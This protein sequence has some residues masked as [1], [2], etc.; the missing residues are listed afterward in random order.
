M[1]TL[2]GGMGSVPL[3]TFFQMIVIGLFYIAWLVSGLTGGV[4]PVIEH[5]AAH[6]KPGRMGKAVVGLRCANPAYLRR[7]SGAFVAPGQIQRQQQAGGHD[8][9]KRQQFVRQAENVEIGA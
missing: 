5:A 7:G 1:Y 6:G 4:A 9:E 2:Y 3:T 8:D